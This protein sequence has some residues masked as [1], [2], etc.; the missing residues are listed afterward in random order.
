V[1]VP[2]EPR[3]SQQRAV[4]RGRAETTVIVFSGVPGTGKTRL[5]EA[6]ARKFGISVFSV[7][8]VLGALAPFGMLERRDRATIAYALLTA[9]V[10]HQLRLGQSAIVDGMIGANE[11]RR[12]LRELARLHG[13]AFSVIECVCSDPAVH[14]QRI[15]PRAL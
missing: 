4:V 1:S 10:D 9:L 13:A 15:E 11:V 12:R 14:R 2:S 6:I 3:S 7:A 8:W 5:A